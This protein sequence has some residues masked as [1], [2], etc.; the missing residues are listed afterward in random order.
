M[1]QLFWVPQHCF[2]AWLGMSLIIYFI[3][4]NR[5]YYI[6]LMIFAISFLWSVYIAIGLVPF[7][8]FY[9][10]KYFKTI[11]KQSKRNILIII[12]TA[13][14]FIIETL[15]FMSKSAKI[16]VLQY[17]HNL[18]FLYLIINIFEFAIIEWLLI[19]IIILRTQNS[20]MTNSNPHN[21]L[22][23]FN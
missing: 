4:K 21:I 16:D 22:T 3:N 9:G 6:G 2:G 1:S 20:I 7:M 13:L 23:S 8:I 19:L 14:L 15:Y 12:S 17:G 10:L 18:D 11:C 5:N